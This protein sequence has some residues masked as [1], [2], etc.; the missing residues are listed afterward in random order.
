MNKSRYKIIIA[1]LLIL[2]MIA[3][4]LGY[5]MPMNPAMASEESSYP[6]M[7]F[8]SLSSNDAIK[9]QADN[10]GLN[11]NIG[12]CGELE[13]EGV[14]CN[15][16]GIIEEHLQV[17]MPDLHEK[18]QETYFRSVNVL[19]D[20]LEITDTNINITTPI[21][22]E[23]QISLEG[24]IS[25]TSALYAE[26]SITFSG[27]VKNSEDCVIYSEN[28]D[29]VFDS[30]NLNL[31]GLVYAPM[32]EI[33]IEG[34]N[35]NLNHVILIAKKITLNAMCINGAISNDMAEFIGNDYSTVSGENG[36]QDN[37]SDNTVTDNDVSDNEVS[38][39]S[40]SENES[41]PENMTEEEYLDWIA[42]DDGDGLLNGLE[43]IIGTN[44]NKVDTDED[45]L[46]DYDEV[47]MVG[48]DPLIFDSLI[49]GISDGDID[50]DNDGI[51][52]SM[53]INLGLLPLSDDSDGDGITDNDEIIQYETEPLKWDT[54]EDGIND[55]DE[56]YLGLNPV[57]MYSDGN[58]KD[59]DRIFHQSVS[60]ESEALSAIN[61]E[62]NPYK[63]S[64]V[65]DGSGRAE[66]ELEVR[67]SA[68]AKTIE[69][70]FILGKTCGVLYSGTVQKARLE[71]KMKDNVIEQLP[72]LYL[73]E[74][75]LQGLERICVFKFY[76]EDGMLFPIVTGY[77][78]ENR[79]IYAEVDEPGC[80]CIGD[81]G[82]WMQNIIYGDNELTNNDI[83]MM[84]A[85][86][87][88]GNNKQY[89]GNRYLDIAFF[90]QVV[91]WD[92]P[93]FNKQK[94][95]IC[96]T[97]KIFKERLPE[98]SLRICVMQTGLITGNWL[99]DD[100]G[101]R[102]FTD[103][104]KLQ[105]AL[106]SITYEKR[107]TYI[108]TV[109]TL[110]YFNNTVDFRGNADRYVFYTT[111]GNTYEANHM[112]REIC[113]THGVHYSELYA[114]GYEYEQ[115]EAYYEALAIINQS[116]GMD[117]VEAFEP[118]EQIYT[119]ITGLTKYDTPISGQDPYYPTNPNEP[120]EPDKPDE[121]DEPEEPDEPDEPDA[122]EEEKEYQL[123]IP[124][125][126]KTITLKGELNQTNGI[127]S[128]GDKLSDWEEVDETKVSFSE[129]GKLI[130]PTIRD[131]WEK[132]DKDEYEQENYKFLEAVQQALSESTF[133]AL[134]DTEYL[135]VKSD[136]SIIDTD[137]DNFPDGYVDT[138][139]ENGVYPY[140]DPNPLKSD[141]IITSLENDYISIDYEYD[142]ES[143]HNWALINNDRYESYGGNQRWF[144]IRYD[145]KADEKTYFAVSCSGNMLSNYG[146]GLIAASD[147]FLY[148]KK[149]EM[150]DTSF[151][152]NDL[153]GKKIIDIDNNFNNIN[154]AD[155]KKFVEEFSKLFICYG[156][157]GIMP[158][159]KKTL[160]L[161]NGIRRFSEANELNLSVIWTYGYLRN[162]YEKN[163]KDMLNH[164][165]PVLFSY[166]DTTT[167]IL[168][169]TLKT[170][171]K[172]NYLYLYVINKNNM[173]TS[174]IILENK[175]MAASHY[176]NAT[177][178]IELSD[179]V[180][181]YFISKDCKK[182]VG[183]SSSG[184][185]CYVDYN[186]IKNH[187]DLFNGYM[188]VVRN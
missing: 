111:N 171:Y 28:G 187:G 174:G 178:F 82:L 42:D 120:E 130:L 37:V 140:D 165:T 84:M 142:E 4:E 13:F 100:N 69:N 108:K 113:Q 118:H 112:K 184:E 102:W 128:D 181:S 107:Y 183:V 63:L 185:K 83:P 101:N 55:G 90:L 143:G 8:A 132:T 86:D 76:E 156:P 144:G 5:V 54:D 68:Y 89:Q 6:Y 155:Y 151:T 103:V 157:F 167:T 17:E 60:E 124:T 9:I 145:S 30:T 73:E 125:G 32:G 15:I 98:I 134:L 188:L 39:N 12:T 75:T 164:N 25:L 51:S 58:I 147:L 94:K 146:C 34:M 65:I 95:Y 81:L 137:G 46:T 3:T 106:D 19:E 166:H 23:E 74:E 11:G 22:T 66:T 141:V 162:N 110:S 173:Y 88:D 129:D 163:I 122:P 126:W 170:N 152:V 168:N 27:D 44:R 33:H 21:A 123:V 41:I 62:A 50:S 85:F 38:N 47:Y 114:S 153:N 109:G 136:P 10:L 150:D 52:N 64:L 116:G 61:K 49:E 131:I 53:E 2:I 159:D 154:Y 99:V 40:V 149:S 148:M 36:S 177:E 29:I 18:L 56:L 79:L 105:T 31:N 91:G 115:D 121:P 160:P 71:F 78:E 1:R 57:S 77:D 186:Q 135:P 133:E 158:N 26:K 48:S 59:S 35:V 80:Y 72:E 117:A 7:M 127:N 179:D 139:S 172:G 87:T 119:F 169:E 96:N 93:E 24:N 70:D 97:L 43:D 14:N 16:N 104:D 45:G 138:L 180:S 182:L 92:Q 67:E 20:N 176:M 161:D 175:F